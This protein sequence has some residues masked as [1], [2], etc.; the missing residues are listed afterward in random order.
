MHQLQTTSHPEQQQQ[1]KCKYL[2]FRDEKCYQ[3]KVVMKQVISYSLF[4]FLMPSIGDGRFKNNVSVINSTNK[5][6]FKNLQCDSWTPPIH[7]E[8]CRNVEKLHRETF[9]GSLG[10]ESGTT[11]IGTYFFHPG[12]NM[13]RR[14]QCK[15]VFPSANKHNFSSL[16]F[17]ADFCIFFFVL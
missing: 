11:Q 6:F 16:P 1:K 15:F 13:R 10:F 2:P 5:M 7:P 9:P 8:Q 4:T 17:V 12:G 14:L 3:G